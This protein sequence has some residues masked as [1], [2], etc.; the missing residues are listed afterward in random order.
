[1]YHHVSPAPGLVTVSPEHF[2]D[3]MRALAEA[4]WQTAGCA[5]L[6][7]FLAGRPLPG[8]QVVLTFDDGYLDN[9]VHAF[10]VLKEFGLKA[11]IF[12]VSDWIGDG[13]PRPD[14]DCPDHRACKRRIASGDADSVILRWSEIREMQASGLVEFQSHTH[15]HTRWDQTLADGAPR[16]AAMRHEL[17]ES[18]RVLEAGLG[19]PVTHL[20]WP[21]GYFQEDYLPLACEAGFDYL[22]TTRRGTSRPGGDA[23]RIKRIVTKDKDGRW[24]LRRLSIYGSPALAW[25]YDLFRRA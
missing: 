4:G 6:A 25:A 15:T 9:Y 24:L 20:C 3:Q 22:H 16:L 21:Q 2:R 1:M 12:L 8:K 7:G 10:P 5:E 18:K 14:G 19:R 11:V 17:T 13:V 23:Q